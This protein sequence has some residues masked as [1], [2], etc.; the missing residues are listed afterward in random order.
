MR[1]STIIWIVV[2]CAALGG[3]SKKNSLFMEA[4]GAAEARPSGGSASSAPSN[5]QSGPARP[6]APAAA[7]SQS[8][9]RP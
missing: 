1:S 4:G 6:S 2:A 3:C 9:Q 5:P 8:A 7:P